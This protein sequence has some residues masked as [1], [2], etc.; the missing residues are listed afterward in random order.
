MKREFLAKL[1]IEDKDTVQAILDE[2]STDIGKIAT[3]RDALRGQLDT[4]KTQLDGFKDVDVNALKGEVSTLKNQLNETSEKYT[5]DLADRD[6]NDLLK[7]I[8]AE[9]KPHKLE[10]VIPFL[11]IDTLKTSKNQEKD[12]RAKFEEVSKSESWAFEGKVPTF[13]GYTPGANDK[14]EV[15]QAGDNAAINAALRSA[16]GGK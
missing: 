2:N 3:E 14:P 6:F 5:R 16:I 11:D 8:S 13:T 15:N 7:T 10:S 1:G 9:F 4:V 12:I